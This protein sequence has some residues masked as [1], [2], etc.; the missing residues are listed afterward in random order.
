VLTQH[1][2]CTATVIKTTEAAGAF[3]VGYHADS[4]DLA[5]DGWLTGSEWDWGPLYVDLVRTILDGDLTGGKYNANYRVGYK[6]GDNPFVQ[7]GFG[8]TVT[9]ETKAAVEQ[10]RAAIAST[11]G[12]PFKGPVTAQDG[13]TIFAEGVVPDYAE[14]EAVKVFVNGVVGELPS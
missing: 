8:P 12:S 2:D 3:S 5:N 14:I 1:Q 7:S 6:T 9:A 11:D 10:A 4:S 13:T